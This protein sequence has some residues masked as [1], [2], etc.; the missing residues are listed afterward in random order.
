MGKEDYEI[1]KMGMKKTST[2]EVISGNISADDLEIG[3]VLGKG[4]CGLVY[5]A[6]IK[7]TNTKVALKTINVYDKER[8]H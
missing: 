7:S 1:G 3:K 6:K 4:A 8:R 5:Q 2:G